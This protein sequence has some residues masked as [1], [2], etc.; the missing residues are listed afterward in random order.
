MKKST[1]GWCTV[2]GMSLVYLRNGKIMGW[3]YH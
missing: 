1:V 3:L 2:D